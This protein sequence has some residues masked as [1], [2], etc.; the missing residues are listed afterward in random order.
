MWI[1]TK[2]VSFKSLADHDDSIGNHNIQEE[3]SRLSQELEAS[4]STSI[5]TLCYGEGW[6]SEGEGL[7]IGSFPLY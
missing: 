5:M 6:Y 7:R 4:P 1:R 2:V 3:G